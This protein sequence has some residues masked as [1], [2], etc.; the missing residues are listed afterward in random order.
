MEISLKKACLFLLDEELD[1]LPICI[2]HQEGGADLSFNCLRVSQSETEEQCSQVCFRKKAED[3]IWHCESISY[4][5]NFEKTHYSKMPISDLNSFDIS[6]FIEQNIYVK[7]YQLKF[8]VLTDREK[9]VLGWVAKGQSSKVIARRL[10][11]ALGTVKQHRKNI[12]RKLGFQSLADLIF[13]AQAFGLC[14]K[15]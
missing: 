13:F 7:Q 3:L 1:E 15:Q 14:E 12:K 4:N 8:E 11:I 6:A 2:Y 10:D 5:K 9:E